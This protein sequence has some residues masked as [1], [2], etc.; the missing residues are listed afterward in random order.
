MSRGK[1]KDELVREYDSIAELLTSLGFM[2]FEKDPHLFAMLD[3]FDVW[4]FSHR[5]DDDDSLHRCSRNHRM[6]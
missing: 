4:K 3:I 6:S 5:D 2:L 1:E